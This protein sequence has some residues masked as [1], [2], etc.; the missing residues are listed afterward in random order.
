MSRYASAGDIA[1]SQSL[2]RARETL[3][4][5]SLVFAHERLSIRRSAFMRSSLCVRERRVK[6]RRNEILRQIGLA[7]HRD[8]RVSDL[9]GGQLRRLRARARTRRRPQTLV[10][11]E[12]TSG[13]DPR[14][15]DQIIEVLQRLRDERGTSFALSTIYEAEWVVGWITVVYRQSGR[16][17]GGTRCVE[18]S[19]RHLRH[20]TFMTNLTNT[21]S[22]TGAGAGR[23]SRRMTRQAMRLSQ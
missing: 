17:P 1:A 13:L 20:C 14:S 2:E 10:C 8:K 6:G 15:E 22:S 21:R 7:E 4:R 12:V 18:C 3:F 19:L 5:F 23:Q 11:D 9:S 16:L